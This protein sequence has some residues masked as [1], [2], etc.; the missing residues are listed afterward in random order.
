MSAG[1]VG[2]IGRWLVVEGL[3][4]LGKTTRVVCSGIWVSTVPRQCHFG[5]L[6][7]RQLRGL[8]GGGG[9]WR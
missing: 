8:Q 4:G 6:L 3:K 5:P 2:L 9:G 1:K 7:G